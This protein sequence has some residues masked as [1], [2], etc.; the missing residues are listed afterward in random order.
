M[1]D[2]NSSIYILFVIER[3]AIMNHEVILREITM[4]SNGPIVLLG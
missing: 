3:H 1:A 2:F 4:S